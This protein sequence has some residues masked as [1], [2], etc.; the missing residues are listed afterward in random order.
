[1]PE[2]EICNIFAESKDQ[3][4]SYGI[5]HQVCLVLGRAVLFTLFDPVQVLRIPQHLRQQMMQAYAGLGE[6]NTVP[7]GENPVISRRQ[8]VIVGQDAEV[9]MDL[10]S[11]EVDGGGGANFSLTLAQRNQEVRMLS[12]QVLQLRNELVDANRA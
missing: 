3:I 8:S 11:D 4:N 9:V 5:D 2:I 7:A 10:V 6:R 1:M 12:S